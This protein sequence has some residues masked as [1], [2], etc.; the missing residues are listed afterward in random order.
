MNKTKEKKCDMCEGRGVVRGYYI[1]NIE[2]FGNTNMTI[3]P[4]CNG[5]GRAFANDP[6]SNYQCE[7]CNGKG[8]I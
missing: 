6:P 3:C 1:Q 4:D 2:G 8:T 5:T 7:D